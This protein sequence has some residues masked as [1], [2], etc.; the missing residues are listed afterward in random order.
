MI[1]SVSRN[2]HLAF[3]DGMLTWEV[4]MVLEDVTELYVPLLEAWKG[5]F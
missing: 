3:E 2:H 4:D 5:S 1:M